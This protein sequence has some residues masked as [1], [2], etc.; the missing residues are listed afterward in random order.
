MIVALNSIRGCVVRFE[1]F[2]DDLDG[3]MEHVYAVCC[4][5]AQLPPYIPRVHPPRERKHYKINDS[6]AELGIDADVL[7]T[8]LADYVA[9][10]QPEREKQ[11]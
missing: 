10:C 11:K 8:E 7:C 6:L 2:V 9:W 3:T 1:D 4:D 5:Q